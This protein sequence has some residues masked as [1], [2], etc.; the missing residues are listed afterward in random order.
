MTFMQEAIDWLDVT[1]DRTESFD[2]DYL[3]LIERHNRQREAKMPTVVE[4]DLRKT[5]W[6]LVEPLCFD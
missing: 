1:V 5:T 6:G 3:E 2:T 4:T